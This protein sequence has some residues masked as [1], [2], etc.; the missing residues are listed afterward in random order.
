VIKPR[1]IRWAWYG[2]GEEKCGQEFWWEESE[3]QTNL[4]DLEIEVK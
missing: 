1:K 3:G 2:G 4:E